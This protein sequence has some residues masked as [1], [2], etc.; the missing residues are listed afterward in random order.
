MRT[1]LRLWFLTAVVLSASCSREEEKGPL[2]EV[3][4]TRPFSGFAAGYGD[5]LWVEAQ[6]SHT[7]KLDYVRV[8]LTGSNAI[9]VGAVQM[10]YPEGNSYSLQTFF[11]LDD[12]LLESGQLEVN[13]RA[14]SANGITND[15][16]TVGYTSIPVEFTSL[17]VVTGSGNAGYTVNS[18]PGEGNPQPLFSFSG[19]YSGSAVSSRFRRLYKAG[20]VSGSF[21]AWNPDIRELSWSF[22]AV[23]TPPLP[24]FTAVYCDNTEVFVARRGAM[25]QG[26]SASGTLNF[27]SAVFG[28]GYFTRIV[29][30][31]QWIAAVFEP[32]NHGKSQLVLFNYPAGS[33]FRQ[34]EFTGKAAALS[35]V[36]DG[37]LLVFVNGPEDSSI[38]HYSETQNSMVR[39]RTFPYGTIRRVSMPEATNAFITTESGVYWYRPESGSITGLIPEQGP[40]EVAWEPLTQ[41]LFVAY[42][43]QLRTFLLNDLSHPELVSFSDT[44]RDLHLMYTR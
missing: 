43:K 44:I 23:S 4:I 12:R 39:L 8:S 26:Y 9:P 28:N 24:Y 37:G 35:G 18:L 25:I 38:L 30:Y 27:S 3:T 2:P 15:W 32:F 1:M 11:V 17:L 19:D 29:H 31:K 6:I 10:F 41:R 20:D 7:E 36:S 16:S 14:G 21:E 34:T 22:P 40:S 5:T 13:V 42:G 33:V